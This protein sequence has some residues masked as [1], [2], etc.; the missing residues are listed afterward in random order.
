MCSCSECVAAGA[1][2]GLLAPS[3]G[4]QRARTYLET[5]PQSKLPT[6]VEARSRAIPARGK[7][8]HAWLV[9]NFSQHATAPGSASSGRLPD[10]VSAPLLYV[11]LL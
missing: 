6:I 11:L 3:A 10:A 8:Q 1:A 9:I 4:R 7:R 5:L 2:L